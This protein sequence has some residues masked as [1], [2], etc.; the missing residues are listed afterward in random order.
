MTYMKNGGLIRI[1]ADSDLPR[2]LQQGFA[3]METGDAKPPKK[4]ARRPK[5]GKPHVGA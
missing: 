2:F 1:V 3:P 5:E 4:T